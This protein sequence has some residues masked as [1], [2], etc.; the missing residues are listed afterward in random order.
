MS[1][2]IND[3]LD[4]SSLDQLNI[5]IKRAQDEIERKKVDEIHATRHRWVEEARSFGMTPE[6][7]LHYSGR[8]KGRPKYRNPADPDQT[9][10]GRGKMPN[11]L[12]DAPNPEAYRIP[13]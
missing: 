13:E 3:I 11:W 5:L 4:S 1:N 6:E 2:T 12:K 9:W 8:R 7:L 10:T